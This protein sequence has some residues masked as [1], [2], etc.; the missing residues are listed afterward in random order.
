[1]KNISLILNAVLVVAVI[2]LY[3]LFFNARKSVGKSVVTSDTMAVPMAQKGIVFVNIDS[4]LSKYDMYTDVI[5]DLQAKAT[6]SENQLRTKEQAF[7]KEAD[8]FQYNIDHGLLKR[9]EMEQKQQE[10]MAKQQDLYK[11]QNNLQ[12]QLSEE[13]QVAERKVITTIVEYVNSLEASNEYN[14]EFVLS[15]TYGGNILYGKRN[16]NISNMVV[17]GLNEEY[18]KTQEKK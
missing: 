6:N 9:S 3:L 16:L 11:L 15:T 1:M 14:Y 8:E 13:Q 10:L 5:A 17:D 2:V 12:M 4:V 7:R 18:R